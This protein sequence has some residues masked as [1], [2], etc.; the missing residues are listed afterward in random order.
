MKRRIKKEGLLVMKTDKSG[1]FSL[2]TQEK[3]LEMGQ[4]HISE[5]TE[6]GREKIKE[7]DK[8]MN[9]HS[10]AW[11]N[12]WSTGAFND[13]ED[14]VISSKINNSENRAKLYLSYKDHKK[15]K[16]KTRPIG[17]A[18]TSNTLAFANSVSDFLES[19]ASSEER[20]FEVISTEDLLHYI[21]RHNQEVEKMKEEWDEK[22]KMLQQAHETNVRLYLI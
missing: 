4:V 15:E 16:Y 9:E 5:D 14:R 20:S 19:I 1:K 12:I 13:H 7:T 18:N 2:T 22:T 21:A 17:T 3:Y 6:I 11:C 8:I 10:R